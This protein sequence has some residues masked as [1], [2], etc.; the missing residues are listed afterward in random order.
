MLW[1][2]PTEPAELTIVDNTVL[3]KTDAYEVQFENG[4]I[5]QLHNKLTT[6]TYTL[7]L[8]V[9][10]VPIG[11]GGRSGL[12]RRNGGHVWVDQIALTAARKTAPLKAELV[13]S[14]RKNEI[15]LFIR[16]DEHTS[17]LLIEQEGISGTGGV[18][19]IQWGCGNL[20]VRDVDLILPAEGGQII[21]ATSPI[22]SK[23]FGYP[24]KW[25]VQ[26]AILQ[27]EHGGFFVRGA[28]ETF[29]F[30][31]LHYEKDV[32]SFALG[33]ETQNQAPF[34]T[35]TSAQS[36][37]W[38][39]NTYRGDWR[40]PAREYRNWMEQTFEPWSLSDIPTWISEIGLV[41]IHTGHLDT[42]MLDKL[43][44]Q[45]DPTKTLLYVVDTWRKDNYDVNYPDYTARS[46]F[47]N[48][49]EIAHQH[50]FRVILHTN[51]LGISPYHPLYAEFQQF[52]FRDPWNGKLIGWR[53]NETENPKRHAFI[54]PASSEFRKLFVQ[55]L[56]A[57]WE[58]Y[59]VEGFH[60]DVSHLVV[61]DA[62][63]LIEGLN[64]AQGN[65]LL[66]RELVEA[67]P[68]AVFSGESLHEVTFFRENFVQR[69]P[70]HPT[71][72]PDPVSTFL[73]SPYTSPYG[74]L[75][76][77]NPDTDPSRYQQIL[78]SYESWGILPTFRYGSIEQLEP[79]RAG[80]QKLLS[81][82][83]AWQQLGFKPDFETDWGIDTLFQYVGKDG[84]IAT[85]KATDGGAAFDLPLGE[86]GYERVFGVTQVKT[87]RSLPH[88]HAY[89]E[90][91]I[92]GLDP[93]KSYLLSDTPRDFSQA[94][95][96]SLPEGVSVTESRVTKNA[97]L[98]RLERI[99]V[100][101]EI[102]LLSQLHLVRQ[103][104]VVNGQE[105]PR[106]K[107]AT[108]RLV[109]T[110]I[111]GIRKTAID[112]HPPWQGIIG[113]TFAEWTLSLPDSS[114]IC[115]EFDIGLPDDSKN[116]D[117]VS[118]IVSIQGN[119][120]FKEHYNQQKWK[121][122]SL[123]LTS[124][125]G[126]DITLRLTTN[127]GPN[128]NTVSDG[129]KW[130]EPKIIAAPPDTLT[131]IGFF[132]PNEP[133]KSSPETIKRIGNGQYSLETLLPAQILFF[134][135]SGEQVDFPYNLRSAHFVAGL[136]FD[137][138]FQLGNVWH[139]GERWEPTIGGIRK[140]S[141][142]AHPPSHGQTVLQFLLSLPQTQKVTFSFAM[143]LPDESWSC[144]DGVS[145][146]VMLNGH[147]QFEHFI[148]THGWTD[149]S[150]SLSE[151]SSKTVL[152]ELV[153]DPGQHTCGDSAQWADLL[154]IAEGA[155]LN[156]DVN[157]DGTVNILDLVLVG[158]N[159]GQKPPSD[160][161]ADVNNDGQ[162]NVLDLVFVAERL[163]EKVAAAPTQIDTIVSNTFSSEEIIV[164]R[165][166]LKELEAM[167]QKSQNVKVAIQVLRAWLTN[168]NQ[169]V[170]E[171]KLLPN[172]P[173]PFNP[174]TW[175]PYQLAE[176]ADV[177]VKIYDI[178]GRL[179]RT[180]PVGFKPIGYYLTQERAAYWDGRNEI[181]ESVS[182]G[183]YFL[184]FVAGDF[185]TTQQIVILK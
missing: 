137:G 176:A 8:S 5:T 75:G 100:S 117:G 177:S 164:V 73:F 21:G 132:L 174:E 125:R 153:T 161:R 48:F 76:M 63:G 52:Q 24:G 79:E 112:A 59:K 148:K 61:N 111:S 107:G 121:H 130:G 26:L 103:G 123:D 94:H 13:F 46:G 18:Y 135:Q 19:G 145:F 114:D 118:F 124:Y 83:R 58:K 71:V 4:V 166:A 57:V 11:I 81:I 62:N 77:P 122:I 146:K 20:G 16:V 51:L 65:M 74:Y 154:I 86:V 171:T 6:E 53:W 82:A 163:G 143:G 179:V 30:K 165:R 157:Q 156:G 28:D 42:S 106:Q 128:E 69:W 127:P 23:S 168:A 185:S 36:V 99:N 151:F 102:D 88:W 142:S 144:S 167:S 55:K 56:K 110:S 150:I 178:G 162:V 131:K 7:P 41:V 184:Q 93:K 160:P 35:L 78:D 149:A 15:R 32:D 72:K 104:I 155:E 85:I 68:G 25:E 181:G 64:A 40:V 3:V 14:H 98:F 49:L 113:D 91:Q 33:F 138:I 9:D 158:Q 101:Q 134:F 173:N 2:E 90:T 120:I 95:I 70:L 17:D 183:V 140:K 43:A 54:N 180:I 141:I 97:A 147:E 38:R 60:L 39:L 139:S 87:N 182:S 31:A 169:S 80:M 34:D 109:E 172:Y 12:L 133:I 47:S 92:L 152:L 108:F 1:A 10:G 66:H 119:E 84:E 45:I 175:I 44:E 29:Q 67:M 89:N 27:G 126:Q 50:G 159:L 129:A 136:Q 22:T 116:S 170:T 37:T 96:N 105:L 115:L